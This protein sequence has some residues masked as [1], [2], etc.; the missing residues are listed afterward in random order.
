MKNLNFEIFIASAGGKRAAGLLRTHRTSL[1]AMF[2]TVYFEVA[3]N[4][5]GLIDGGL[6]TTEQLVGPDVWASWPYV[7]QSRAAGMCLAFLVDI[8][9]I[10]LEVHKTMSGKGPM[11][12]KLPQKK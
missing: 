12:Y 8:G 1:R 7:G 6:Y 11:H 4:L 9:A 10:P 5:P 3:D 2:E